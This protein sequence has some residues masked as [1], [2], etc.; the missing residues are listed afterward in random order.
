MSA[1]AQRETMLRKPIMMPPSMIEKVDTIARERK[2]SFAEVV[3]DAVSA[4]GGQ[5]TTEDELIL[6]TLADTMIQTTEN[7]LKK[8]DELEKRLDKTHDLLESR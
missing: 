3:R 1:Q 7:L 2:V 4:F 5:P 8:I 6:D